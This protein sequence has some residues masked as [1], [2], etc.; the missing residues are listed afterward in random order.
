M[1]KKEIQKSI[2]TKIRLHSSKIHLHSSSVPLSLYF[3][4]FTSLFQ[5][6]TENVWERVKTTHVNLKEIKKK[7][8]DWEDRKIKGEVEWGCRIHDV[9]THIKYFH[10]IW[11]LFYRHFFLYHGFL[12]LFQMVTLGFR[13]TQF[14]LCLIRKIF[15]W[16]FS[17]IVYEVS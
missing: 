1:T 4:L 7:W 15:R 9:D 17:C 10:F 3:D 16:W 12:T 11:G 6:E 2:P 14:T 5:R 8:R 13:I